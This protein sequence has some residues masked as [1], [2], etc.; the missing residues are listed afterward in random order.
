MS[1]LGAF[2]G[3]VV[4]AS[5]LLNFAPHHLSGLPGWICLPGHPTGLDGLFHQPAVPCLLRPPITH[6]GHG[7]Y[8]N[9]HR[10]S[11]AYALCLGLG[12]D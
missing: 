8:R 6:N 7:W 3:S 1:W 11:I 10:L 5:S 12:P 4:V 2:L 9:V